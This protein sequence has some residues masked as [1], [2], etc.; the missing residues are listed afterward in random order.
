MGYQIIPSYAPQGAT[1]EKQTG[2]ELLKGLGSATLLIAFALGIVI[3]P[4]LLKKP[5]KRKNPA[6]ERAKKL[7]RERARKRAARAGRSGLSVRSGS[8]EKQILE[9]E[10]VKFKR[11]STAAKKGWRKRKRKY[12]R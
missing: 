10:G 6:S 11:R 8:A 5:K 3:V 7:A 2:V 9:S 1:E 4:A 12:R